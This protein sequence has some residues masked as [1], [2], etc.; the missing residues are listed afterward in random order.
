MATKRKAP[1]GA[2]AYTVKSPLKFG[3]R[4]YAVG[5]T[6]ELADDEREGIPDHVLELAPAPGT[7]GG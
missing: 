5:E 6:I 3:G 1:E 2:K 4:R 7:K